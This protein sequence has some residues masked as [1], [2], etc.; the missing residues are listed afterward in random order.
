MKVVYNIKII[1]NSKK[2]VNI[3]IKISLNLIKFNLH[4][5]ENMYR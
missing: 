3:H 1:K 4:E 2:Q 5:I